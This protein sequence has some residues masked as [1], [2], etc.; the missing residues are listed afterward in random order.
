M[1][2]TEGY[3]DLNLTGILQE[4]EYLIVNTHSNVDI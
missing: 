3:K 4:S 1:E 2:A